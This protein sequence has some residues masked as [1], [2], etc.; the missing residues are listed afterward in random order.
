MRA[1]GRVQ[2]ASLGQQQ[3]KRQKTRISRHEQQRHELEVGTLLAVLCTLSARRHVDCAV[4]SWATTNIDCGM[5][6]TGR[7]RFGLPGDGRAGR[8]P[9]SARSYQPPLFL[10]CILSNSKRSAA[11]VLTLTD[12]RVLLHLGL[13]HNETEDC[14][15]YGAM[16]VLAVHLQIFFGDDQPASQ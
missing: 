6:G 4:A 16:A 3:R 2:G 7:L 11:S 5:A 13:R 14:I 1:T 8:D 12:C 9:I 15:Q 10:P